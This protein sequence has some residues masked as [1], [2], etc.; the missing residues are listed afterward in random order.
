M[1]F[2]YQTKDTVD[3]VWGTENIDE[4]DRIPIWVDCDTG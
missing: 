4:N 2:L 3:K 1:S